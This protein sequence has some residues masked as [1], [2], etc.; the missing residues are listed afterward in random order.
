MK[1]AVATYILVLAIAGFA[2]GADAANRDC[3]WVEGRLSAYN[4]TPSFRIWPR[5]THRLLGVVSREGDEDEID[6]LPASIRALSPGFGKDVWGQ[7]K[8]CPTTRERAGWMRLGYVT[9][10]KDL[11]VV[12]R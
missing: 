10:A 5:N 1:A 11:V 9:A 7:F 3:D 8:F 4:G 12:K 6:R 2:S